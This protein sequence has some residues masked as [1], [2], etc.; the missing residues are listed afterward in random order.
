MFGGPET[1]REKLLT[2]N[3]NVKE[4][5]RQSRAL[6]VKFRN[7]AGARPWEKK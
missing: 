2:Q 4:G 6:E 1:L 7:A 5:G 3:P